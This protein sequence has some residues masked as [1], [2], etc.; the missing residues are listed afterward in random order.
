MNTAMVLVFVWLVTA[1]VATTALLSSHGK[2][3]WEMIQT[4]AS[5]EETTP[6]HVVSAIYLDCLFLTAPFVAVYSWIAP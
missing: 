5:V 3:A 1:Q 2:Q 4:Q 6:L